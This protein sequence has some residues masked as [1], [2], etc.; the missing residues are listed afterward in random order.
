MSEKDYWE[1]QLLLA[2]NHRCFIRETIVTII[3]IILATVFSQAFSVFL[4]AIAGQI[5]ISSESSFATPSVLFG[6]MIAV[7]Q[8]IYIG[9]VIGLLQ[10]LVKMHQA[11]TREED[12]INGG[13]QI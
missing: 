1:N 3:K 2:S 11:I 7:I 12:E 9:Y 10:R 4:W 5:T 13:E 6:L 8:F